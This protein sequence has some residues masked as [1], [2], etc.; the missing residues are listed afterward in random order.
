MKPSITE[1]SN[2]KIRSIGIFFRK[3]K[4]FL[5]NEICTVPNVGQ[6]NVRESRD[7]ENE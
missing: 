3:R 5:R 4:R 1:E 2:A 7:W 6:T